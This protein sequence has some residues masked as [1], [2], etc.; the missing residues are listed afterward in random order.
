MA[1]WQDH[2]PFVQTEDLVG[3]CQLLALLVRL[4][5]GPSDGTTLFYQICLDSALPTNRPELHKLASR[6]TEQKDAYAAEGC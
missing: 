3:L 5:F 1:P 2:P 4:G 6:L